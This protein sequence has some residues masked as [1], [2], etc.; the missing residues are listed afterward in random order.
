MAGLG[1]LLQFI[2]WLWLVG[3]FVL[4]ALDLADITVFPGL[5]L[6]FVAR[7]LR[8]QA[9]RN[10]PP[11]PDEVELVT[12]P[13]RILNTDRPRVEPKPSPK[14]SPQP[15]TIPLQ[16]ELS[17]KPTRPTSREGV[18]E[19]IAAAGR[20]VEADL[21]KPGPRKPDLTKPDL[22]KPD[23]DEPD[24]TAPRGETKPMSSEEMIAAAHRRWNAD[25]RPGRS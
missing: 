2:G 22:T 24:V 15:V 20:E 9:A 10:A 6:I 5:I 8:T 25:K 11:E 1:R 14:P 13:E 7:A 19:R 16:T 17:P 4:P 18:I 12:E 21:T 3:G 23:R